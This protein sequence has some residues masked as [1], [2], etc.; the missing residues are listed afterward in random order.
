MNARCQGGN[1][2]LNLLEGI[3][4]GAATPEQHARTVMETAV[5]F[6][7]AV[8]KFESGKLINDVYYIVS[9]DE[10]GEGT[11]VTRSRNHNADTWSIDNA[12]EGGQGWYRL[13][14]NYDHMYPDSDADNRRDPGEA[15]MDKLGVDGITE[16]NIEEGVLT[17]WPTFNPHTDLTCVMVAKEGTYDCKVWMDE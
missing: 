2:L 5:S 16:E 3:K 8:S 11:V 13:Q 10:E 1:L 6:K 7:D 4:C 12:E 9:G 17:V 15:N 14:T